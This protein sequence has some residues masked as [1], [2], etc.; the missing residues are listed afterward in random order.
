M[1]LHR[2]H[3]SRKVRVNR[4]IL[5]DIQKIRWEKDGEWLEKW[6]SLELEFTAFYKSPLRKLFTSINYN[7]LSINSRWY[8]DISCSQW[9]KDRENAVNKNLYS[10][11]KKT[12]QKSEYYLLQIEQF[13]QKVESLEKIDYQTIVQA[14]EIF[15]LTWYIFL[16]DLGKPLSFFLENFLTKKGM[17]QSEKN[18]IRNYISQFPKQLAYQKESNEIQKIL[19]LYRGKYKMKTTPFK[20]LSSDIKKA[21]EKHCEKFRYLTWNNLNTKPSETID[22]Y[23]EM[24][25]TSL[26]KPRK[27][28]TDFTQLMR[29]KL[30][31][32]DI[33]LLYLIQKHSYID[34]YAFD[35]VAKLDYLLI[36][37]LQQTYDISFRDFTFYTFQ[38]IIKLVSK[39]EIVSKKQLDI[40]RKYRAMT[41]IKGKVH[42][43]YGKR[44]ITTLNTFLHKNTIETNEKGN[45]IKG[46]IANQGVIQGKVKLIKD[47]NDIWKVETGDI[48]VSST[49]YPDL[50]L[51]IRK[52]AGIITD[53]GGITSHAAIISREFDIPC[54]VG[55]NI[56]TSKLHDGDMIELDAINGII[57]IL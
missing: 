17:R 1:L 29:K 18:K 6:Y 10:L 56:A 40:R 20:N 11:L 49:T 25:L 51:A 3:V 33:K 43:L 32:Q 8:Y 23:K 22:Y 24:M 38:E 12:T 21:L 41:Q 34:N 42:V 45:I 48:L 13:T 28:K 5:D 44:N 19:L 4:M 55:T 50:M 9:D 52:C 27:R 31:D 36:T 54:I 30:K 37:R 39:N 53:T 15:L 16:A 2:Q 35:L 7:V 26:K 46:I 14:K 57:K 47:K